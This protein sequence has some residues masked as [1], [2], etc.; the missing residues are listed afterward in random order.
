MIELRRRGLQ[1][2]TFY[3]QLFTTALFFLLKD[4]IKDLDRVV[5]DVEYY[6]K[7]AQIKQHILHLLRRAGYQVVT[8]QIQFQRIGKKSSA[9]VLA[10]GTFQGNRAPNVV[11]SEEKLLGEFKKK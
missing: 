5:I 8:D 7:E 3:I 2:P 6:G 11:L 1:G 10:L 9:H 4:H